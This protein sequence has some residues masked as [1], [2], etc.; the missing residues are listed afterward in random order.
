MSISCPF[1]HP[2]SLLTLF[3]SPF[4]WSNM[5]FSPHV[6]WQVKLDWLAVAW[7]LNALFLFAPLSQ[8]TSQRLEWQCSAVQLIHFPMML[9]EKMI[10]CPSVLISQL[11]IWGSDGTKTVR[12]RSRIKIK[13]CRLGFV[14]EVWWGNTPCYFFLTCVIRKALFQCC[15]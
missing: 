3:L 5:F 8:I 7:L 11:G 12:R 13:P 1:T 2:S 15:Q 4:L 14:S 10:F 9:I 6:C